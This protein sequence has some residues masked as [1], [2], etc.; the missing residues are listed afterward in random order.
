M[1]RVCDL[2]I[3]SD[4][5]PNEEDDPMTDAN[6][7]V[8]AEPHPPSLPTIS[9]KEPPTTTTNDTLK[10]ETSLR[11]EDEEDSEEEEDGEFS[12]PS[13]SSEVLMTPGR[14]W[15]KGKKRGRP[16]PTSID[17]IKIIREDVNYD[18]H[19]SPGTRRS[20]RNKME[21]ADTVKDIIHSFLKLKKEEEKKDN[22]NQ[23]EKFKI[24]LFIKKILNMKRLMRSMC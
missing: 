20:T 15:E 23:Q 21:K 24:K 1:G 4:I 22:R 6:D 7:S 18:S 5:Q 14:R 3:P 11:S 12:S 9:I 2:E 10:T 13:S 19:I 17:D 8:F 16:T